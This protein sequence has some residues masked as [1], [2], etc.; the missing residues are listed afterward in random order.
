MFTPN[1]TFCL[2]VMNILSPVLKTNECH[3]VVYDQSWTNTRELTSDECHVTHHKRHA[4]EQGHRML[5][6]ALYN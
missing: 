3:F 2:S 1:F 6:Q 4:T 5:L